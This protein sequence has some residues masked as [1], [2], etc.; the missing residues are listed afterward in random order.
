MARSVPS[1]CLLC[2]RFVRTRVLRCAKC[3]T[4]VRASVAAR[5]AAR[6]VVRGSF[7]TSFAV[8]SAAYV[9]TYRAVVAVLLAAAGMLL[10]CGAL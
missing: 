3:D 1:R 6:T 9:R 5:V 8:P 10:A 2:A 4:A 7:V